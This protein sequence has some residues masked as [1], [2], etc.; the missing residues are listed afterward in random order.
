M[1][2]AEDDFRVSGECAILVARLRFY[3]ASGPLKRRWVACVPQSVTL[4]ETTS[5]FGSFWITVSCIE[6]IRVP[7]ES[8][9]CFL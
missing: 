6:L 8:W 5:C 1:D 3:T 9:P 2:G 4:T 7:N